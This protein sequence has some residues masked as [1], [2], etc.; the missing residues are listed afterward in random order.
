MRFK[1]CYHVI[2]QQVLKCL[3]LVRSDVLADVNSR[4]ILKTFTHKTT[5][6]SAS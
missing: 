4:H 1:E 6:T 3:V 5:L 2:G